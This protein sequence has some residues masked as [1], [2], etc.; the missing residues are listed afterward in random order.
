MSSSD[1]YYADLVLSWVV[2]CW[3]YAGVLAVLAIGLS[4]CSRSGPQDI[5]PSMSSDRSQ[6]AES[7]ET[8]QTRNRLPHRGCDE[9]SDS[10]LAKPLL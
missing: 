1:A 10:S 8:D 4:G 3:L 7:G 9:K 6:L 2:R 5:L